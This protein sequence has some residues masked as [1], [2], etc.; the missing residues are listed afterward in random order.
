MTEDDLRN[1]LADNGYPEHVVRGGAE[2]LLINWRRFVEEVESG[3]AFSIYD[4]RNDLDGRAILALAGV[5]PPGIGDLDERLRA[6]LTDRDV[7]VWESGPGDPWWDFG[8]PRGAGEE[9]LEDL[10][11]EGLIP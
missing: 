5:E 9:F 1:Y 11:A 8:I 2:G 10:R 3:Y 7:R 6:C 4:Y